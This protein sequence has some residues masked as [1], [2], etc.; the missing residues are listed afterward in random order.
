MSVEKERQESERWLQQARADL[1]AAEGSLQLGNFEWACLQ[2]QQGGEK[3]HKS[4]WYYHGEDPWGHSLTKLIDDFPIDPIR[5]DLSRHMDLAK[6]LDKLY[7]PTRYPN[8]LPD[9]TPSEA[10][11]ETEARSAKDAARTIT[12]YI[13]AQMN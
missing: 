9:L 5:S 10:Y 13:A 6:A 1:R 4:L 2:S 3:A 11:T 8:G 7:I 12:D